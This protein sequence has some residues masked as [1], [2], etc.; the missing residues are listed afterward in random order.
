GEELHVPRGARLDI[1]A[2]ATLNPDV[3]SLDRVELVV[4]GDVA[5]QA[6]ADGRTKVELHHEMVA[7]RSMWI[8]F[9]AYGKRQEKWNTTVAHSA[10]IYVVVDDAP[11]WKV[12]EVP[13]LVAKQ[14]HSLR[15]LLAEPIDPKE[16]LE[17]FE[18]GE[19]L[20]AQWKAQL[21]TIR[22]RVAEA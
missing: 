4:L 15:E 13:E 18:T 5:A 12:E 2:V 21:P 19:L 14:R 6:A 20:K 8:A 9:R 3:D 22:G 7:D 1:S 11:T 10:P 17:A 16:D